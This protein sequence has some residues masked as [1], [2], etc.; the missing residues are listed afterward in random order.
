M[1]EY[2][3]LVVLSNCLKSWIGYIELLKLGCVSYSFSLLKKILSES[4]RLSSFINLVSWHSST[5]A[6]FSYICWLIMKPMK[7]PNV[8]QDGTGLCPVETLYP[9]CRHF[10]T[11]CAEPFPHTVKWST[12]PQMNHKIQ[13]YSFCNRKPD[14]IWPPVSRQ[15]FRQQCYMPIVK[16]LQPKLNWRIFFSQT[17]CRTCPILVQFLN[18]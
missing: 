13:F 17:K 5:F 18:R 11:S 9:G 7:P 16:S 4:F 14:A 10:I 3:Q 8:C 12:Y 2:S 1:I 15:D 6:I